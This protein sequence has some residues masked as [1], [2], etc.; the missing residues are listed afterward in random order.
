M[1]KELENGVQ[2]D[3]VN[4]SKFST[5]RL[6]VDFFRPIEKRETTARKLLSNI[7][8]HSSEQY[9]R[10]IDISRK[11]MD[12]YGADLNSRNRQWS[13]LNDM[14]FAIEMM[15]TKN[16]A[17]DKEDIFVE[18][19]ALLE[20]LIFKPLFNNDK[21]KFSE[22]TYEV[23]KDNIISSINSIKDNRELTS[24]F[25]LTDILFHDQK[26]FATPLIGDIDELNSITNEELVNLYKNMLEHDAIKITVVGNAD[27]KQIISKL[28]NSKFVS[29]PNNNRYKVNWMHQQININEPIIEEETE[30]INQ[31]R[32]AM[33]YKI[34][35]SGFK[36]NMV[37][38]LLNNLLGGDDQSLLF[39]NVRE[40]N[41]LA[42]SVNS[43]FN[44]FSKTIVIFAGVEGQSLN[45]ALSLIKEQV[46][47]LQEVPVSNEELKHA[48]KV[49]IQ[50]RKLSNDR[51]T[52]EVNKSIWKFLRPHKTFNDE[53]Y[54]ELVNNVNIN[55][56]QK[57]ANDLDLVALY[58]LIGE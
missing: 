4:D 33:A 56:I 25:K 5:I 57:A 51:I 31:S 55:E 35:D 14:N 9:P 42:Y 7:L 34:K 22:N 2:I 20:S 43:Q 29:L 30:K 3:V 24:Y 23:E 10:M 52:S 44:S 18:S 6:E 53:K 54:I 45:N 19:L 47:H 11:T 17:N 37:F 28:E 13:N 26:K 58:K 8:S 40:K 15:D 32:I 21:T 16:L 27:E 39:Q 36:T 50:R 12:L 41:S 38:Q 1:I 49:L 48:K 46:K